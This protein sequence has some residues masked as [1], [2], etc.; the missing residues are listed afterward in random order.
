MT[1]TD[2]STVYSA[3]SD[4]TAIASL[5]TT[6]NPAFELQPLIVA[7]DPT[8]DP[9]DFPDDRIDPNVPTSPFAGVGSVSVSVEGVGDF[10]GSG[11]PISRRH[12]L[13]AAHVLD[14]VNDDGIADPLPG[15]VIFNLN[16]DGILSDRIPASNLYL[17]PGFQGFDD[18]LENDLAI[19]E[20]SEDLPA[21]VPIYS[22]YRQPIT[23][24]VITLVGYGTSGSGVEG[25][26]FGTASFDQNESD[27]TRLIWTCKGFFYLTLMGQMAPPISLASL[28]LEGR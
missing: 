15:D 12:V 14:V 27:R 16:A 21:D 19:I 17:F 18:S 2:Q 25:F 5:L 6:V 7:G 13:T 4:D 9:A 20:L 1:L 22:L 24:A 8:G 28:A 3:A 26:E 11:T 23:N 10:L